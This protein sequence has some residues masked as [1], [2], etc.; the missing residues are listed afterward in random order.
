[1]KR[2]FFAHSLQT[3]NRARIG[4]PSQSCNVF[5]LPGSEQGSTRCWK[6]MVV[7]MLLWAIDHTPDKGD[8]IIIS[9]VFDRSMADVIHQ[10]H[11]RNYNIVVATSFPP[12]DMTPLRVCAPP[13][14][15]K[16]LHQIFPHCDFLP[17][18]MDVNTLNIMNT[19]EESLITSEN[20]E[21]ASIGATNSQPQERESLSQATMFCSQMTQNCKNLVEE[22]L[23]KGIT[24]FLECDLYAFYRIRHGERL[25]YKEAGFEK[26]DAFLQVAVPGV[27]FRIVLVG[28]KSW[29]LCSNPGHEPRIPIPQETEES[30]P[31][32]NMIE[33][34]RV[35]QNIL[36]SDIA[37]PK[38]ATQVLYYGPLTM[39]EVR[40]WLQ[41]LVACGRADTGINL[42]LLGKD[43]EEHK[44]KKLNYKSL[45][46]PTL[47]VLLSKF[48]N[49]VRLERKDSMVILFPSHIQSRNG[50]RPTMPEMIVP[51]NQPFPRPQR[52]VC[53]P[54]N[55]TPGGSMR[56]PACTSLPRIVQVPGQISIRK[57]IPTP[58][59]VPKFSTAVNTIVR[60]TAVNTV[61]TV[62][63]PKKSASP[64]SDVMIKP[65]GEQA[66]EGNHL[67][68]ANR[69]PDGENCF[70]CR[71]FPLPKVEQISTS[72]NTLAAYKPESPQI[73]KLTSEEAITPRADPVRIAN[74]APA[75][76][77]E[78]KIELAGR[79]IHL[80]N[81]DT[82]VPTFSTALPSFGAAKV[83]QAS[84]GEDAKQGTNG[85]SGSGKQFDFYSLKVVQEREAIKRTFQSVNKRLQ[86]EFK[87]RKHTLHPVSGA[88]NQANNTAK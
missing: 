83:H 21:E 60:A 49:L 6:A 44:G 79:K 42:S 24:E 36:L 8:V 51:V 84:G 71:E 72:S 4:Q 28:T 55:C 77:S 73:S 9:K 38:I 66:S 63:R 74:N 61:N 57:N 22:F 65:A 53:P 68:I 75:T 30:T 88:S 35:R 58:V 85:E 86:E 67:P 54:I 50:A 33:E 39:E 12:K 32:P 13:L 78:I 23:Q 45:H 56:P 34:L 37:R 70:E 20:H 69:L 62:I 19:G 18:S 14:N 47:M 81:V 15:C 17:S 1:M 5:S 64:T 80:P 25:S 3:E 46:C 11:I 16:L 29:I 76:I 27:N 87:R 26:L 52:L 7:D 2:A 31:I 43:F 48:E 41:E 40:N 10:L 59:P 82:A